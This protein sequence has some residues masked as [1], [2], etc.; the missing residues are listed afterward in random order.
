MTMNVYFGTINKITRFIYDS[1]DC[2]KKEQK[3]LFYF[4]IIHEVIRPP[5]NAEYHDIH[6]PGIPFHY[7]YCGLMVW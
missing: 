4:I 3:S 2:T 1:R 7:M 5:R 6:L